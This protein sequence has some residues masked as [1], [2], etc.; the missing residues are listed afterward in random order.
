[1]LCCLYF[2]GLSKESMDLW[3]RLRSYVRPYVRAPFPE[4]SRIRIFWFFVLK[5]EKKSVKKWRF[6]FF[7]ENSKMTPFWPKMVQNRPF[8]PKTPKN[9]GF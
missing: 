3:I 4:N 2:F 9:G 1:M 8:W 5:N 6:R 7:T